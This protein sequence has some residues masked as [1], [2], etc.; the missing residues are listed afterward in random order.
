MT[1]FNNSRESIGMEGSARDVC[2]N[3]EEVV[4]ADVVATVP[5]KEESGH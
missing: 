4:G 2:S 5:R 1:R 3:D